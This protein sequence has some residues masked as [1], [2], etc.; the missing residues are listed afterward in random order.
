MASSD[1]SIVLIAYD[2]SDSARHAIGQ[3]GLLFPA[4]TA[5]V[6]TAWGSLRQ[7]AGVARAALPQ[8]LIDDAVRSLDAAAETE[9][10]NQGVPGS[11]PGVGS[12]DSSALSGVS[13]SGSPI[14][15]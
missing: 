11:N 6:A 1:S 4:G 12:L 8:D 14:R 9:A 3:A 13:H 7:G 5:L 15:L 10:R 2:G